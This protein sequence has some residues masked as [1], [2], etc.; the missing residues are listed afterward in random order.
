MCLYF[1][2]KQDTLNPVT[3]QNFAFAA[4]LLIQR[5]LLFVYV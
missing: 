1:L 4:F 2:L 3:V 5:K